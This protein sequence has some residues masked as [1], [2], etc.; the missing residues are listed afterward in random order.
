MAQQKV[1]PPVQ[2]TFVSPVVL[3]LRPVVELTDDQ[4]LELSSL[5]KD[6]RLERTAEGELVVLPPT[7]GET[8]ERNSEINMQLRLFAKRNGSG[9]AFD[10]NG[11]FVLPNGATRSPDA[12]WVKRER[13]AGLS[14]EQKKKFLPLCPDFVI[15]LRSPSDPFPKVQAKIDEYLENGAILGWLVDPEERKV[16]VY[17]AEVPIRILD[18]PSELAGV[19]VLPS[20]QLDLGQ[21]WTSGF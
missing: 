17:Q 7:G 5:N 12:S 4:L 8:S 2:E 16:H 11:G 9:V 13:L 10:S 19:P 18:N 15:E 6:L 3:R 20:F 1:S 21:V 14:A